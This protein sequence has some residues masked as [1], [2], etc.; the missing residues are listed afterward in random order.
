MRDTELAAQAP[1]GSVPHRVVLPRYL[2]QLH[3]VAIGGPDRPAL[4]GMLGAVLKTYR[5]VAGRRRRRLAARALAGAASASWITSPDAGTG[6]RPAC[7]R[8]TS[9]SPTT[10]ACTAPTCSSAACGWPRCC[11]MHRMAALVEPAAAD[12]VPDRFTIGRDAYDELL[13]N[14]EFYAQPPTGEAYRLRPRLPVRP[15]ARPV[16][17]A[18]AGP[19]PPPAR[20]PGPHRP[21]LDRAPQ[22]AH[23]L[24]G[25]DTATGS[26][27]T[28]TTPASSSAAGRTA[29]ARRPARYCDEVWTGVEYQVAAHCLYE[30]LDEEA[31]A[32]LD[33]ACRNGTT[34]RGATRSTR[35]SAAT[36]T[37]GR[38]PAGRCWTRTPAST[39]TPYEP[40]LAG[41][42]PRGPVPVRRRRR[43]GHRHHRRRR[44]GRPRRPR[45]RAARRRHDTSSVPPPLTRRTTGAVSTE[46]T[47][48]SEPMSS[49]MYSYSSFRSRQITDAETLAGPVVAAA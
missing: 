36:T 11:S 16:V 29:A 22:P 26:S 5:S 49:A 10:S 20:R 48:V 15:A 31:P 8:A 25:C 42:W 33:A 27:P 19:G 7:C 41:R 37:C 13:W 2:P 45:R 34:A 4:D 32:I 40:H 38:W 47:P 6:R 9:R 21:R 35:S 3:G 44:H 24:P 43:L 28:A 14:G 30:G 39:T 18:P 17:G 46:V 12:R 1:D 23:R